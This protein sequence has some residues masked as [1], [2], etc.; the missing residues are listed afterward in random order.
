M[1]HIFIVSGEASGDVYGAQLVQCLKQ[2]DP[3]LIIAGL[4]G[5]QMKATGMIF[6]YNLVREFSVMG[7]LPVV[8]G[9]P[10][11]MRFLEIIL[12]YFDRHRPDVLVLIDYPGFNMYLATHA[13]KRGI[14]IVYY[15]T[16]QIWAWAPWRIK[17]IKRL[18]DKMLVIFPFEVPFYEVANV[19]V[20]YVGHPLVDKVLA[21]TPNSE[22]LTEY[23]IFPESS[24]LSIIPGSRRT[25]IAYNLPIML[26]TAAQIAKKHRITH[27]LLPLATERYLPLINQIWHDFSEK[28]FLPPL[29]IIQGQTYNVMKASRLALVTSGTAALET[30][31]LGTPLLI[32]YR[33]RKIH[34]WVV[35]HTSFLKCKFFSLPNIITKKKIVPEY[36]ITESAPQY[37]LSDVFNLWEETEVRKNCQ[38]D[39]AEMKNLLGKPGAPARAAKA[40]L[41]IR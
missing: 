37:I 20:E 21:F 40:I 36:L 22:F 33:V 38:Q 4:G 8:L 41:E 14:R 39:L 23:N 15:V 6:L 28:S 11:V 18:M 16:P 31:L 30:A 10:K 17:K 29:T 32:M 26:W 35:E 25:I 27:L 13:K 3:N 7:F 5:D 2:E 9:I 34:R 24:V 1:K 12:D 19:P